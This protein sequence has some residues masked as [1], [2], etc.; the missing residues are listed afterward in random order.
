MSSRL[1][2][3]ALPLFIITS[4]LALLHWFIYLMATLSMVEPPRWLAVLFAFGCLSMPMSLILSMSKWRKTLLPVIVAGHV[5]MGMFMIAFFFAVIE[6][7]LFWTG[8]VASSHWVLPA[9]ILISLWALR[10]NFVAPKVI[11]HQ[12]TGPVFMRG[13]RLLQISDLHV[14]MGVI[15]AKWLKRVADQIADLKVDLI[16]ITG[17]LVDGDFSD[18]SPMLEPLK[19]W[20][21][22]KYYVTGN[23]EYIRAANWEDRLRELDFRVLHNS[24]EVI[25]RRGGKLLIGGVPDRHVGS[26]H[27]GLVSLPDQALKNSSAIDYR[28][29]LAHEPSS[30]FDLKMEKPDLI[31]SGHTHGGQIFPFGIFVRIV[32][33]VVSGFKTVRGVLLFAHQ[34]TGFWGP[35]MRWFTRSEIVIFEW[36]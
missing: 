7:V 33:P 24:H 15:G 34:G 17:D 9:T 10:I 2:R 8:T 6:L 20:S 28:I 36:I 3:Y 19:K 1:R 13:F 22:P 4:L 12:I 21:T 18:T 26:F 35:P 16:A 32:Q 25:E 31:I 14:G 5:W 27:K 29:L 23:H 11:V 30:V